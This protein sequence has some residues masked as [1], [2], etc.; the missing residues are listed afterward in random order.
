MYHQVSGTV[1]VSCRFVIMR[2]CLD[3]WI[4]GMCVRSTVVSNACVNPVMLVY[5]IMV[6]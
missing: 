3:V 4:I 2:L 5:L 1:G 6:C